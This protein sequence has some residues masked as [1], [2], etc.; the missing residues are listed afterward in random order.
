MQAPITTVNGPL[1]TPRSLEG[2]ISF[3]N[4][5]VIGVRQPH[6]HVVSTQEPPRVCWFAKKRVFLF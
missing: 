5:I 2:L 6:T 3:M 4:L 1:V